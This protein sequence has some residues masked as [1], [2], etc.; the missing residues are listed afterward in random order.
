MKSYESKK[1]VNNITKP[2]TS[3]KINHCVAYVQIHMSENS[4][5]YIGEELTKYWLVQL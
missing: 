5:Y 3:K 4:M 2:K 1:L